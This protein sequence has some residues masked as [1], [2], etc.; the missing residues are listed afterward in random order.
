MKKPSLIALISAVQESHLVQ[1]FKDL[2]PSNPASRG[3]GASAE[4]VTTLTTDSVRK[5]NEAIEIH[6]L[7]ERVNYAARLLDRDWET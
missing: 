7:K 4:H 6:N 1:A 3:R 5:A 2:F